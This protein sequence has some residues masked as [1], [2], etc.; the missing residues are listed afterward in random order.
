V[1]L[2]VSTSSTSTSNGGAGFRFN[3]GASLYDTPIAEPGFHIIVWQI[4]NGQAYADAKMFV[5]GTLPSNTFTG[6]STSPTNTTAF[7]GSDLELLLGTGRNTSG[8][9]LSGDYFNGQLAEMLVYNEQLSLGQINL[10]ANYLSTEYGLPFAYQTNLS[11]AIAGDHNGDSAVDAA[12]YVVWRKLN[13][14]GQQGYDDWRSNFGNGLGSGSSAQ[15]PEPAAWIMIGIV[16]LVVGLR[17][18]SFS[19]IKWM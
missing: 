11:A 12:D 4:D 2:D 13:T 8:G 17:R 10:V 14:N 16:A 6:S 9:L 7:S 3:D 19:L 5:D 15:V 18:S 1:G